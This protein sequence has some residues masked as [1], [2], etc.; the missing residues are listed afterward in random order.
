MNP[1]GRPM[2]YAG[3]ILSLD[4]KKLY[5]VDRIRQHAIKTR[6]FSRGPFM[7]DDVGEARRRAFDS[8]SK[9]RKRKITEGRHGQVRSQD[10]VTYDAWYGWHW[11]LAL[12][13]KYQE[14]EY[15]VQWEALKRQFEEYGQLGKG[16]SAK[17]VER[18]RQAL[19]VLTL[20]LLAICL[21]GGM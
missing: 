5:S 1:A 18:R 6:F 9:F 12:P 16:A 13:M 20:C 4:D 19:A 7:D 11:K 15:R 10:E 3:L 21:V 17:A 14:S 8:L 2:R